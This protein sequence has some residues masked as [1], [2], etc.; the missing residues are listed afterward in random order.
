MHDAIGGMRL[1]R[2]WRSGLMQERD[3]IRSADRNGWQAIAHP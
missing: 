3:C 1:F 2:R